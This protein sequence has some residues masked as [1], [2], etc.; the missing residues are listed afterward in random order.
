MAAGA[1][2]AVPSGMA[3]ML[4]MFGVDPEQIIDTARKTGD[5]VKAVVSA[6]ERIENNQ[7]AIMRHFGI[8]EENGE[9]HTVATGNGAGKN[10]G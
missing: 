2:L 9:L 7:K 6:L 1:K 10:G 5:G 4:K 3:S 8:E